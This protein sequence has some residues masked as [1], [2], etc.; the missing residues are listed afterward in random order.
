MRELRKRRTTLNPCT[1]RDVIRR[2]VTCAPPP[3]NFNTFNIFRQPRRKLRR[4]KSLSP[5]TEPGAL[6]A[7]V[8]VRGGH[9]LMLMFPWNRLSGSYFDL[10]RRS[11]S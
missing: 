6:W 5:R 2:S 9:G 7:A 11:R 4:E 8:G 3:Q 10:I 1:H